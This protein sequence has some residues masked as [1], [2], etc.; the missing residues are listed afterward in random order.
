M[1]EKHTPEPWRVGDQNGHGGIVIETDDRVVAAVYLNVVST[2]WESGQNTIDQPQN[3]EAKANARRL[4]A[5]VN[6]CELITTESLESGLIND[7]LHALEIESHRA[8]AE[9]E[10]ESKRLPKL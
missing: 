6:A 2:A 5:C 4:V 7:A 9:A 8:K 3:A 1:D 10:R